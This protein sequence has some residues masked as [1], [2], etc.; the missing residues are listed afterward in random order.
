VRVV[1]VRYCSVVATA[2]VGVADDG[3]ATVVAPRRTGTM[4]VRHQA[5][6]DAAIADSRVELAETDT[7]TSRIDTMLLMLP[8]VYDE[9]SG[10]HCYRDE[11][12]VEASEHSSG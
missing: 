6:L 3:D 4:F 9:Q 11:F 12:E 8:T 7:E 5:R 1:F 2:L 10:C